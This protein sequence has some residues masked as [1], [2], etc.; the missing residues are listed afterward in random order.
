MGLLQK[1]V[2]ERWAEP[3][4]RTFM[5]LLAPPV[6]DLDKQYARIMRVEAHNRLASPFLC[7]AFTLAALFALMTAPHARRGMGRR[8]G[9]AGGMAVAIQAAFMLAG[10]AARASAYATPLVYAAVA[11]PILAFV[12]IIDRICGGKAAEAIPCA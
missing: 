7:L 4:D 12:F 3:S 6:T 10:S 11:L 2:G 9:A 1:S 8:I 5:E